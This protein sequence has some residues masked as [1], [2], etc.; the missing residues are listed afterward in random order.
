[1]LEN[2]QDTCIKGVQRL[3]ERAKNYMRSTQTLQRKCGK[4]HPCWP[5]FP[6]ALLPPSPAEGPQH[7]RSLACKVWVLNAFQA[8]RDREGGKWGISLSSRCSRADLSF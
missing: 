3:H 1:M 6:M 2:S 7:R 5:F 4:P 8:Q